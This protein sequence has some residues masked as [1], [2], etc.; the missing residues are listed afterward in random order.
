M[1]V[2][3][4]YKIWEYVVFLMGLVG[5]FKITKDFYLDLITEG[6]G[7]YYI[8]TLMICVSLMSAPYLVRKYIANKAGVELDEDENDAA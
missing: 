8:V 6:E 4:K 3:R 5:G 7:A 1:T 2:L